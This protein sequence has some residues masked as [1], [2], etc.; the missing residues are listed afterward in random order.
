M[1]FGFLNSPSKIIFVFEEHAIPGDR[2]L[3]A[4]VPLFANMK[5]RKRRIN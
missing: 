4:V 5:R 3:Q 2:A 1:G